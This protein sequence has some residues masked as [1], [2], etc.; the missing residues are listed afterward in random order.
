MSETL[1]VFTSKCNLQCAHCCDSCGPKGETMSQENI[2][3]VLRHVPAKTEK[4]VISGGEPFV[5]PDR[6]YKTIDFITKNKRGIL[7][8]GEICVQ[9]NGFWAVNEE[10]A[11]RTIRQLGQVMHRENIYLTI[12]SKDRFHR[13]QG[14]DTDK[15]STAEDSPLHRTIKRIAR[16]DGGFVIK[17]EMLP[18]LNLVRANGNMYFEML[19]GLIRVIPFGRAKALDSGS[20]LRTT[21]CTMKEDYAGR[22]RN[23]SATIRPDG[24][25]YPCCWCVTPSIGSAI[26]SPLEWLVDEMRS[27]RMFRALVAHGPEGAARVLGVYNEADEEI[28]EKNPCVKCEEIFRGMR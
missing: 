27:D 22:S 28:Y 16:Q 7:P 2:E 5:E 3:Q 23:Y 14:L 19:D 24:K 18:I 9:T 10:R 4:L 11:Y 25:V 1:L 8:K 13:E 12:T 6:L 21:K 20:H 26:E 15:L 17:N